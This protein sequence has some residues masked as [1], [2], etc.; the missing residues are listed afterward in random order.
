M[1]LSSKTSKDGII[2]IIMS[3]LTIFLGMPHGDTRMHDGIVTINLPHSAFR[4][5]YRKQR[6]CFDF[7]TS[8]ASLADGCDDMERPMIKAPLPSKILELKITQSSCFAKALFQITFRLE[9]TEAGQINVI[10]G[11]PKG[12]FSSSIS[13]ARSRKRLLVW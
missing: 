1:C 11:I 9:H 4:A 13:H 6:C 5:R 10:V 2:L 12:Y 8:V 3:T 7:S